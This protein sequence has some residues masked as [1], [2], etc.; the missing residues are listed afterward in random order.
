MCVAKPKRGASEWYLKL[1]TLM[2]QVNNA[3]II[4]ITRIFPVINNPTRLINSINL[5]NLLFLRHLPASNI[6]HPAS[7]FQETVA[8]HDVIWYT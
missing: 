8:F 6:Q 3:C 2:S 4:L 7:F 5:S 1:Q